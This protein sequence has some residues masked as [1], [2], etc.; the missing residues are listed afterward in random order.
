MSA[1]RIAALVGDY[2]HS[3]EG[4]RRNLERLAERAILLRPGLIVG[5]G[6]P[7]DRFTYWPVRVARGGAHWPAPGHPP[8]FLIGPQMG[9]R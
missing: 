9:M 5:P 3:A 4:M 1:R 2:Y 7:T 6:D 8:N